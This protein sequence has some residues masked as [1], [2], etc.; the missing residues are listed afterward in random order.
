M[1]ICDD[2]LLIFTLKQSSGDPEDDEFTAVIN[3]ECNNLSAD[4]IK[5]HSVEV[6]KAKLE[7]LRR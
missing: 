6:N 2:Q 7:E 5:K 4:D 3:R 1:D